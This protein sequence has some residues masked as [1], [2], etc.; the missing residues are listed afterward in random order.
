[1]CYERQKK[2]E[3]CYNPSALINRI[4]L[5]YT[6]IKSVNYLLSQNEVETSA[7]QAKS[8]KLELYC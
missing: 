3:K 8:A 4:I 7:D 5:P 6:V 1:M 2:T